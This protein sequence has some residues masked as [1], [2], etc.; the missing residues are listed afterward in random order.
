[1]ISETRPYMEALKGLADA[2]WLDGQRP[3]AVEH[4]AQLLRLNPNDNQGIRDRL[5]PA[6]I[7][8]G[9]DE[10]A[11]TLL[12]EYGKDITAAH[13]FNRA[14][15]TFRRKGKSK[16]AEKRL[17]K[18]LEANSHVPDLLLGDLDLP[19]ELPAGFALGSMEEA[20]FYFLEAEEAWRETP[21]ALDWLAGAV[22]SD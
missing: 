11:E 14:L 2:L 4:Y 5:A 17:A 9:Q 12:K 22:E 18:A 8:M 3:E 16:T 19:D 20:V 10:A 15:V 7:A 13:K 21:G 6:L 1:M